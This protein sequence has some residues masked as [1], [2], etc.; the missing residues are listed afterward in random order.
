MILQA[1]DPRWGVRAEDIKDEHIEVD[2]YLRELRRCKEHTVGPHLA[3]RHSQRKW[4]GL[5]VSRA[6]FV[7]QIRFNYKIVSLS[8]SQDLPLSTAVV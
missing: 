8:L 1:I 4:F 2:L 3:V 7:K 6:V 5:G